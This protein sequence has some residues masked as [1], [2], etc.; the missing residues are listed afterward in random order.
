[1]TWTHVAEAGRAGAMSDRV[2][3]PDEQDAVADVLDAAAEWRAGRLPW[4]EAA[5][6][7][8]YHNPS[9]TRFLAITTTPKTDPRWHD[10]MALIDVLIDAEGFVRCTQGIYSPRELGEMDIPVHIA[11]WKREGA[12]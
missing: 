7:G 6:I 11:P 8:T 12:A 9:R 1:M 5:S 2:L 3:T 10:L 4:Q